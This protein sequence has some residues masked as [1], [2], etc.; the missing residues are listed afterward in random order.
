MV[1]RLALTQRERTSERK[2]KIPNLDRLR[3]RERKKHADF[4]FL[5]H[6]RHAE[7]YNT[8]KQSHHARR[9]LS[10]G[11]AGCLRFLL[12]RRLQLVG[13]GRLVLRRVR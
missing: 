6:H 1:Y 11:L 4:S 7:Q 9:V 8:E 12:A 5:D 2:R 10:Y 13:R 3:E